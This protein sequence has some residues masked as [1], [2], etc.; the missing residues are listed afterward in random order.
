MWNEIWTDP[1]TQLAVYAFVLGL[2]C[3]AFVSCL[4]VCS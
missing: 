1:A 4:L 3:G 2:I